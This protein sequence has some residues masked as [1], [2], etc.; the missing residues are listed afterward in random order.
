MFGEQANKITKVEPDTI[1][2][3]YGVILIKKF[4]DAFLL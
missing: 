4:Y 2:I 1:R 3:K